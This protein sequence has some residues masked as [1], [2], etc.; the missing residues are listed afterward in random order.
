MRRLGWWTVALLFVQLTVA[1][2]MR[3]NY[4]GMAIPT[5]PYSTASGALLPAAWDFRVAL[6]FTHRLVAMLLALLFASYGHVLL[7]ETALPSWLR[8]SSFLLVSLLAVQIT[9]GAQII[10]TGRSVVM[11]TSHVLLGAFTLAT[12]FVITFLI[13]RG[14]FDNNAK[15]SA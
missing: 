11:T 9:L 8:R 4:A 6:Q 15:P 5:F 7:R 13:H 1:A 3:H 12:T 10:W 2:T 14:S